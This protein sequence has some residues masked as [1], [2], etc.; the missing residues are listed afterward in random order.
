MA[1]TLL[2]RPA[3]MEADGMFPLPSE[4]GAGMNRAVTGVIPSS[5][6]RDC[7][8]VSIGIHPRFLNHTLHQGAT[9][10]NQ[11]LKRT[12]WLA[13]VLLALTMLWPAPAL[14]VLATLTDD[15]WVDA[16]APLKAKGNG[17]IIR[18]QAQGGPISSS[19]SS[20]GAST[21][22]AASRAPTSARPP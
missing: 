9:V 6:L 2:S 7:L 1:R 8:P 16:A 18:V 17:K 3:A 20:A 10:R 5:R 11:M 13:A 12:G 14:A 4:H 22:R 19:A 21:C 15:T